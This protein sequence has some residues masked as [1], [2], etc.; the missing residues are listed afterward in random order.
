MSK[1]RG[2]DAY[3]K[4]VRILIVLFVLTVIFGAG[5]VL[6]DQSIK[7]QEADNA[8]RAQQ[9]NDR[10]MDAYNQAK[11]EEQAA[12]NQVE[13]PEWPT[14]KQEGWDVIDVSE[15]PL[16]N[17]KTYTAAREELITSGML[18]VNRW[19][20]VPDDLAN[21]ELLG[22][23]ATDKTIPT[24]GSKVRLLSPA[25]TGSMVYS[26]KQAGSSALSPASNSAFPLFLPAIRTGASI[27]LN[28]WKLASLS[29]QS[30]HVEVRRRSETRKY[31]HT[32][33]TSNLRL[34]RILFTAPAMRG[35]TRL[36]KSMALVP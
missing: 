28:M 19:H 24:D 35:E 18:L 22:V 15:F 20:A 11:A 7:A 4:L 29:V 33:M 12:A 31:G 6:L 36:V 10:L 14:P 16:T 21:C 27:A 17:T 32:V 30:L 26:P 23:H 13:I 25:I 3:G 1:K 8:A 2:A 5:Y 9:E 34:C